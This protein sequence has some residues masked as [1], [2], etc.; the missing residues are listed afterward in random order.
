[1]GKWNRSA[2]KFP[3]ELHAEQYPSFEQVIREHEQFQQA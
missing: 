2:A 3:I 1:L